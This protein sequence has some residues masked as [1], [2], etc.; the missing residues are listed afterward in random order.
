[1]PANREQPIVQVSGFSL[2]E[3]LAV[4]ALLAILMALA[5]PSYQSSVRRANRAEAWSVMMKIMH[6][7]ERH[8]SMHGSYAAF[9]AA[10]ARGFT[11]YSG[12]RPENSAYEIS[13]AEC[14]GHTLKQCVILSAEPGT[15][16]VRQGYADEDCGTLTLDSAGVRTASGNGSSCW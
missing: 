10:K 14:D 12:G 1:M 7:Q 8:Y 6:E 3:L 9:S 4:L 5:L 2:I 11:W 16:K 13:A 15:S